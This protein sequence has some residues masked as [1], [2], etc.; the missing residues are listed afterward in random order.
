MKIII[1][2]KKWVAFLIGL[3]LVTGVFSAWWL[4]QSRSNDTS[5]QEMIKVRSKVNK[6]VVLPISEDPTLATVTDKNS[7]KDNFLK[8][9]AENGD[10]VLVY[11]KAKKVY[12]YRPS[13]NRIVNIG[14]LTVDA[15]AGEVQNTRI[16]VKTGN[17]NPNISQNIVSQLT[18][19]YKS[20]TVSQKVETATRQNYPSTIIIDLTDGSK[21]D[22]VTNLMQLLN[23]QRG[24]LPQ[25]EAK[26][27]NTDILI[28]T[29]T[30][31]SI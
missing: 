11:V 7:L 27:D 15:S 1:F 4:G 29:G 3:I 8:A 19:N 31:T 23:A 10:K 2:R 21:Y 6:L 14:P 16:L 25:G 17:N 12:I 13:V 20:A 28:I 9:N 5:K 18:Q 22:L 30:D 26:P 24:I